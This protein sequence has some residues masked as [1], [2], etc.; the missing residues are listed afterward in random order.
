MTAPLETDEETLHAFYDTLQHTQ[1]M[2]EE[3]LI[4]YQRQ[5][6]AHMLR[7]A[8]RT[9]PFYRDR[10]APV[11][12]RDDSINWERWLEIPIVSRSHLQLHRSEMLSN[13]VPERH[14]EL[15]SISTSGTTGEPV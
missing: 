6:L 9:T 5:Q 2:P 15:H 7:H 11:L 14:G 13:E 4:A 3:E 8:A 12:N 10:L 1:W